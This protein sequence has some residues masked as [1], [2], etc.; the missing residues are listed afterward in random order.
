[1]NHNLHKE[2]TGGLY[3][4][5]RSKFGLYILLVLLIMAFIALIELK[6]PYY[7]LQDDNR[8]YYLPMFVH[9][10]RSLLKGEIAQY[11]FYQFA[12][13]PILGCGQSGA[14]YPPM[15]L[16][17]FISDVLFNHYFATIE[18][19]VLIHL[20]I[21]AVGMNYFLRTLSIDKKSSFLCALA[22]P[23][24]GFVF[25]VSNS[26]VVIS[27]VCAYLP[28]I[29]C[30]SYRFFKDLKK[31][32]FILSVIFKVIFFYVGF[33]QYFVYLMIF[34]AIMILF[35][36]IMG[37]THKGTKIWK[38]IIYYILNS[39][40]VLILALP[41]FLPVFRTSSISAERASAMGWDEYSSQYYDIRQWLWGVFYPFNQTKKSDLFWHL[42]LKNLSHIGYIC[43]IFIV[44][45][46]IYQFFLKKKDVK[47]RKLVWIFTALG[48][49]SLLWSSNKT[50]L[51]L[52]YKI[53]ILNRFRWPFKLQLFTGFFMICIASVGL[54]MFFMYVVKND[55]LKRAVFISLVLIQILNFYCLYA[56][57]PQKAFAYHSDK[58]PLKDELAS[59]LT[60]GRVI[61]LAPNPEGKEDYTYF[62]NFCFKSAKMLGFNYATLWEVYHFAG[63]DPLISKEIDN[64]CL[65]LNHSAIYYN[66]DIPFDYFR[67]WGVKWYVTP[68]GLDDEY[69]NQN[70]MRVYED[71]KRVIFYDMNAKPFIYWDDGSDKNIEYDIGTNSIKIKVDNVDSD[72]ILNLNFVYNSD[73]KCKIDGENAAI[74]K[75]SDNQMSLSLLPG[76]HN[77]I[78]KYSNPYFIFGT[79]VACG[80]LIMVIIGTAIYVYVNHKKSINENKA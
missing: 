2:H 52:I 15:Y 3:N 25:Q 34:D 78:I 42:N 79:I 29:L 77:I 10:Y 36:V 11:N 13:Y 35:M 60:N 21:G 68:K 9:S 72:K 18:I 31:T 75:N 55:I 73:F 58:L 33:Y 24:S 7:F 71:D 6:Y 8:D 80:F 16:S 61:T 26:W 57:T 37:L 1:M 19:Y 41:L 70:L 74:V 23:L 45:G 48:L 59:N 5:I 67:K 30:F 46:I 69:L 51:Y 28:W 50:V 32:D 17:V 4:K 40:S 53:P 22:W 43:L 56:L 27:G 44:F 20:I 62:S 76:S 54:Y 49:I 14:L 65:R 39:V 47:K 12:G 64:I 63:Y 38:L 66:K